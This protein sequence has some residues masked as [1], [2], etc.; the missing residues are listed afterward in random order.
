MTQDGLKQYALSSAASH[1]TPLYGTAIATSDLALQ[2]RSRAILRHCNLVAPEYEMKWDAVIRHSHEPDYAASDDLVAFASDNGLAFH[3]HTLWWH[4][5]IPPSHRE[6][7]DEAFA[8]A[9][10]QHLRVT[11]ARYAGRLHSWDVVNEVLEPAHGRDD[12]LRGTRFLDAMGPDYIGVAFREAAALD[13]K[14]ILVLNEMGLEYAHPEADRKR[15]AMIALLERELARGTPI[16]CLG[17]QSHLTA[18]EQPRHHPELRAFL[19]EIDR[20][21]LSVMITELD[22]SDHLCPRDRAERDR[23]VADTYGAYLDLV[24]EE[25]T[26]LAVTTWG[27]SDDRTWLNAFRPRPDGSSQRPL[28]LDRA[29]RRKPAWHAIKAALLQAGARR[30]PTSSDEESQTVR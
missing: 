1:K 9:A 3:G 5:S 30:K 25:S 14:A 2:P 28:P 13:P 12:G 7:C 11:T 18:M 21:G 23:M 8:E 29:L 20:M 4:E 26:V 24:L 10:L 17:I 19:R 27:L 22:V 15:R 6:S 16:A